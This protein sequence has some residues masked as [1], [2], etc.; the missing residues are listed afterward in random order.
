MRNLKAG[1]FVLAVGFPFLATAGLIADYSQLALK[2][3]EQMSELVQSK[4]KEGRKYKGDDLVPL[5][6]GLQ[7]VFSRPNQD[8]IIEKVVGPLRAEVDQATLERMFVQ[9]TDEALGALKNPKAFQ[10]KVLV[11]YMIFLENVM[12]EFKPKI[13]EKFER[14]I[15]EKIK[16]ANVEVPGKALKE[17]SKMGQGSISP[18]EIAKRILEAHDKLTAE[19]LEQEKAAKE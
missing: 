16:N 1:I 19:K 15:F 17:R 11:T 9:L 3:I 14:S 5:K 13:S 4:V 2:N 12:S 7:A 18:S 8:F 10:P 6:E